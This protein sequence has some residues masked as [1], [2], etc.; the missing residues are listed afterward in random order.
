MIA[1]QGAI[2]VSGRA[3]ERIRMAAAWLHPL[4]VQ[5]LKIAL[6]HFF[7]FVALDSREGG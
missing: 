6:F 3:V 5:Y 1:T 4:Q 7:C 2:N